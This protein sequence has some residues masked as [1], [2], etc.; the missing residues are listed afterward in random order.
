MTATTDGTTDATAPSVG[1]D[2][3]GNLVQDSGV[4]WRVDGYPTIDGVNVSDSATNKCECVKANPVDT[5]GL[6]LSGDVAATLTVVDDSVALA[7]AGLSEVCMSGK[8]YK[9]DNSTGTVVGTVAIDGK[10]TNLNA[11]IV[12]CYWRGV[13]EALMRLTY[14]S[15]VSSSLPLEYTRKVTTTDSND[16]NALTKIEVTAGSIVYFILPQLEE[17]SIATAPII[18]ADTAA[19]ASRAADTLC[20]P[21]VGRL[22][23]NDFWIDMMVVPSVGGQSFDY[24]IATTSANGLDAFSIYNPSNELRIRKT[25]AGVDTFVA[26]TYSPAL[27]SLRVQVYQSSTYGMGI[28][29]R[30][31]G[32]EW[33]TWATNP[34]TQD[35]PIAATM[36]IGSRDG[37]SQ[38]LA[39]YP[40]VHTGFSSDPKAALEARRLTHPY[41]EVL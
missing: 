1:Y 7:A 11:H 19:T 26:S 24:L 20:I 4:T 30:E 2:D 39:D 41:L 28:A 38:F 25:I 31:E 21:T 18:G 9:L 34:D 27:N 16:E 23:E 10:T 6:T 13:G 35:A 32:G 40:Y 12:C 22:R 37:A 5:T 36:E 17:G 29:V 15:D 33:I 3:I 8:V 14:S